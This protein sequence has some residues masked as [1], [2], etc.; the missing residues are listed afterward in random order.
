[1]VEKVNLLKLINTALGT[2]K[3]DKEKKV[4]GESK[5]D[6]VILS[7]IVKELESKPVNTENENKVR[8]IQEKIRKGNYEVSEE[9]IRE[10]LK[11]FFL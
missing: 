2:E 5:E 8:E 10:G 7:R 11:R 3:K 6:K 9:K 1:M 4:S